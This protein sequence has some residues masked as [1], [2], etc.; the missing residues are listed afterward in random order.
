MPV[1]GGLRST[2]SRSRRGAPPIPRS[3]FDACCDG[4]RRVRSVARTPLRDAR[5]GFAIA[6]PAVPG[7]G[8]STSSQRSSELRRSP[9][10]SPSG[11]GS[12]DLGLATP[13]HL[14]LRLAP[15]SNPPRRRARRDRYGPPPRP[16]STPTRSSLDNPIPTPLALVTPNSGRHEE[17]LETPRGGCPRS[18]RVELTGDLFAAGVAQSQLAGDVDVATVD[19]VALQRRRRSPTG[20]IREPS[21]GARPATG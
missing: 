16:P 10:G 2:Q 7:V 14:L 15:L 8:R 17:W 11:T 18:R 4:R 20:P 6:A 19:H 12:T 21:A 5:R 9:G 13:G 3:G 1:A